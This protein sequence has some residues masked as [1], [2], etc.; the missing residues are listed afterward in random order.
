M[1]PVSAACPVGSPSTILHHHADSFIRQFHGGGGAWSPI[2]RCYAQPFTG[3]LEQQ[4]T[5]NYTVVRRRSR[6]WPPTA[7]RR[8]RRREYTCV[9]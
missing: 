9:M 8:Q 1:S 7:A 2:D 5:T 4:S 3:V 6:R